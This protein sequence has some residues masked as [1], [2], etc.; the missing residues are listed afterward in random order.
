MI[1]G[2]YRGENIR[3]VT[4]LADIAGLDMCDVLA[5]SVHAVM[6]VDAISRD[7]QV[8]EVR[9]YPSRR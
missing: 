7:V 8:I 3:V 6:A 9:R 5:R 1:D 2:E 4:I